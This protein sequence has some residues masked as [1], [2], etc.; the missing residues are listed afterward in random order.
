MFEPL[1]QPAILQPPSCGQLHERVHF[2]CVPSLV[3]SDKTIVFQ[4][5]DVVVKRDVVFGCK[6]VLRHDI[7]LGCKVILKRVVVFRC[8]VVLRRNVVFRCAVRLVITAVG[9]PVFRIDFELEDV[10]GD[11]PSIEEAH[12]RKKVSC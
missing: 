7:V 2:K 11:A 5:G 1:L 12:P 9:S 4:H 8:R 10:F 6:I 3:C